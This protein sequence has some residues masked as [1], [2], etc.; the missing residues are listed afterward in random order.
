MKFLGTSAADL[1]PAPLCHC[2]ICEEARKNPEL[3]RFRSM[4]L[5]D[6]KNLIDCG[7]DF[8]AALMRFNIDVTELDNVFITHTHADHFDVTNATFIRMSV[9]RNF[10]PVDVWLSEQGYAQVMSVI[11]RSHDLICHTDAMKA[12][13]NGYVRLHSIPVGKPVSVGGYEVLAVHSA[14]KVSERETAVNYLFKKDGKSLLYCLDTPLY[15]DH[16]PES[17]EMLKGA[18]VDTLIMEGTYGSRFDRSLLQ[19]LN[20][21]TFIRQLDDFRDY[22]IIRPGTKIYCTH[23]THNQAWNH[24]A[25]QKYLDENCSYGVTVALDGMEV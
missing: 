1:C 25:Y 6:E 8:G 22:G 21:K 17:L 20:G 7:P 23:L 9:T 19:H 5:L 16:S 15:A 10:R 4:F 24:A 2:D 3:M 12:Y 13:D 18:A 11:E 14:H